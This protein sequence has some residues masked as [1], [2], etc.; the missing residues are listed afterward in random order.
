MMTCEKATTAPAVCQHCHTAKVTRP[1]GLCWTCYYTPGLKDRYPSE[2]KY[3]HRGV[4]NFCGNAPTPF[5]PTTAA[6][7]TRAKLAVMETRARLNQALW[8][9]LDARYPGD[10]LPLQALQQLQAG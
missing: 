2:S 10:P 3:A 6:P 7:G 9:P 8:H 1:R 4:G 5:V